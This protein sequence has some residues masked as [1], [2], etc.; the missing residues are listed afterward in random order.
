MTEKSKSGAITLTCSIAT[1]KLAINYI[2][3]SY[4]PLSYP[5]FVWELSF[6]D[7]LIL[8][9]RIMVLNAS[10]NTKEGTIRC[11]DQED[12]RYQEMRA[13]WSFPCFSWAPARPSQHLAH[14]GHQITSRLSDQL[15]WASSSSPGQAH[16]FRVRFQLAWVCCNCPK[17]AFCL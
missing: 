11:F 1:S 2:T 12:K 16:C 13:K 10:Y 8:V 6:V 4:W 17:V 14:L 7:L 5:N 3:G 9:S 15:A